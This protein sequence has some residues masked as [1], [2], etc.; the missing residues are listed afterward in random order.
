M[1]VKWGDNGVV[2]TVRFREIT[3]ERGVGIVCQSL[4]IPWTIPGMDIDEDRKRLGDAIKDARVKRGFPKRAPYARHLGIDD[5]TMAII[6]GARPG[7]VSDSM[8]DFVAADLGW[9][10]GAWR[11]ILAG[12][13]AAMR[14]R[15]PAVIEAFVVD[16][17]NPKLTEFSDAELVD[18]IRTRMLYMAARLGGSALG[19]R[20]DAEGDT[21]LVSHSVGPA[22][23]DRVHQRSAGAKPGD[24]GL[25]PVQEA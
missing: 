13:T 25:D 2:P 3:Q 8:L 12:T 24:D 20:V 18:E 17:L 4:G 9:A 5:S 23:R 22:I 10:P 16:Q 1:P 11:A 21:E 6:E 19:W 7:V 14:Q 15:E